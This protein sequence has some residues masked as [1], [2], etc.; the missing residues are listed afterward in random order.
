MFSEGRTVSVLTVS[1]H[2][3]PLHGSRARSAV[4]VGDDRDGDPKPSLTKK[5]TCPRPVNHL[6]T[7]IRILVGTYL[8]DCVSPKFSS[9]TAT[10]VVGSRTTTQVFPVEK[11]AKTPYLGGAAAQLSGIRPSTGNRSLAR[12]NFG[13][14]SHA[15]TTLGNPAL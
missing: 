10:I 11:M 5:G 8:F 3:H 14:R 2:T 9:P 6:S 4:W 13:N 1:M 15:K 7:N 12:T